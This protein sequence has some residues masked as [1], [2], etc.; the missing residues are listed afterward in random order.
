[1]IPPNLPPVLRQIFEQA[2]K[3]ATAPCKGCQERRDAVLKA[4]KLRPRNQ[5][6]TNARS[7]RR[8]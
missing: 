5:A 8:P 2:I 6:V 7:V 3:K 4:L 1:M